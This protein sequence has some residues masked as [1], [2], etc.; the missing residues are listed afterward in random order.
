MTPLE[1]LEAHKVS[2]FAGSDTACS[3]DRTW[4]T[5]VEYR[6]HVAQVLDQN[7][8]EAKA[9]ALREAA[10][11]AV[12]WVGVVGDGRLVDLKTET[13]YDDTAEWLRDRANQYSVGSE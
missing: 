6:A 12:E 4:R 11:Y 2:A 7:M 3:C 13:E 1:I 10:E 5:N 9:E 8:R